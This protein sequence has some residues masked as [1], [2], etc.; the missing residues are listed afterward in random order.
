MRRK[1]DGFE[2]PIPR[3]SPLWTKRNH[4]HFLLCPQTLLYNAEIHLYMTDPVEERMW[5]LLKEKSENEPGRMVP[6]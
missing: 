5:T 3:T 1:Y 2:T 6:L 4:S